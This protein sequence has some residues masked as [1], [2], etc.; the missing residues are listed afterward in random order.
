M[1]FTYPL[2]VAV[3]EVSARIGRTTGKG[4]A[5]NVIRRYPAT[6][7]YSLVTL[8]F[9]ANTINIGADLGAM[10]DAL[11]LLIG[12]PRL[13]FVVLFGV[14]C[15][16]MQVFMQYTRYVAVLK[17]LAIALFSYV[18]TLFVVEVP[19]A[20]VAKGLVIPQFSSQ[21]DYWQTIVAIFGTTIS[22]YLFFWQAS[23]EVEDIREI[24]RREPLLKKPRQA[25]AAVE[26]I[27]HRYHRR[28]G[29]F[30]PCCHSNHDN[31]GRNPPSGRHGEYRDFGSGR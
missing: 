23:Q 3:Q 8:L 20:N 11:A 25:P 12:G 4:I 15:T 28:H 17:W 14:A 10:G 5:G 7:V 19:W 31:C 30:K 2:M 9:V 16:F 29:F 26:R 18:V 1:V 27:R 13:A 6:I 22:P 21:P 24:P